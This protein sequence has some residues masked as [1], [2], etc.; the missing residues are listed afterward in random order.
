MPSNIELKIKV[1]S[2]SQTEKKLKPLGLKPPKVLYQK[3]IYYVAPKGLL[4]LRIE[5]SRCELIKYMRDESE[6]D[7]ISDYKVIDVKEIAEPEKFFSTIFNREAVVEKKRILYLYKNTRIHL[8]KV[9]KLGNF[10]ELESVV[11]KGKKKA[12]KEFDEVVGL[13]GIDLE[14]QIRKSYRDLIRKK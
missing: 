1:K 7:R 8:D 4:K 11:V 10:I 12:L 3:D 14:K 9:S 5:G 2:F 13:L 6:P